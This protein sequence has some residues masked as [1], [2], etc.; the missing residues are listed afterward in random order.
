MNKAGIAL[1]SG[2]RSSERG[3]Q[4]SINCISDYK[5][6]VLDRITGN[7]RKDGAWVYNFK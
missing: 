1:V 7:R 4:T 5:I 6:N 3:K 2:L